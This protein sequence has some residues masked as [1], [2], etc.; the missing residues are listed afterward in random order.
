MT[1]AYR[2]RFNAYKCII[3]AD[4]YIFNLYEC[5]I[6]AYRFRFND[7]GYKFELDELIMN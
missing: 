5:M 6:E 2:F 4:G 7:D 3:E 1:E